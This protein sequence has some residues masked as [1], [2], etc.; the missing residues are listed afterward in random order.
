L[1]L[2]DKFDLLC[3]LDLDCGDDSPDLV[4]A[5]REQQDGNQERVEKQ[6]QEHKALLAVYAQLVS[7]FRKP[8]PKSGNQRSKHGLYC[9]YA[10]PLECK[11]GVSILDT[12]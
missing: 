2:L 4:V 12:G 11:S 1:N 7:Q 9:P 8:D 10:L 5:D 3:D 6:Q